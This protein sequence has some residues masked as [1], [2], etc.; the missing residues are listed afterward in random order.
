MKAVRRFLIRKKLFK[1]IFFCNV[2][3]RFS[4]FFHRHSS[5]RHFLCALFRRMFCFVPATKKKERKIHHFSLTVMIV[6]SIQ[7]IVFK[8]VHIVCI[9]LFIPFIYNFFF[10]P[11]PFIIRVAKIRLVHRFRNY[12]RPRFFRVCIF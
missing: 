4:S 9:F 12:I 2:L 6:L 1:N 8:I 3:F 10:S 11:S 7:A 5:F